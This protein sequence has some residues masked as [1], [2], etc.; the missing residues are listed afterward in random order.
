M[1][2]ED[3][4]FRKFV[5][6][7]KNLTIVTGKQISLT[8]GTRVFCFFFL[9]FILLFGLRCAPLPTCGG[10]KVEGRV[11]SP[12]PPLGIELRLS[13]LHRENFTH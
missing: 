13:D 4:Y 8:L 5:L 9:N 7:D 3:T 12:L 11:G 10:Q 1:F 6:S 2:D